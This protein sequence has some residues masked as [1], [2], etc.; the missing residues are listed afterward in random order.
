VEERLWRVRPKTCSDALPLNDR[1]IVTW[2]RMAVMTSS[3]IVRESDANSS[4]PDMK[5]GGISYE[6]RLSPSHLATRSR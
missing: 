5:E 2:Q 3:V 1:I 6:S 4:E